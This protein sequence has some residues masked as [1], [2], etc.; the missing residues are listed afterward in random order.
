M[1]R[2]DESRIAPAETDPDNKIRKLELVLQKGETFISLLGDEGVDTGSVRRKMDEAKM[3]FNGDNMSRAFEL[4]QECIEDLIKL[5]DI[6]ERS[7][8][9]VHSL[10]RDSTTDKEV[11]RNKEKNKLKEEERR[12][13]IRSNI[14]RFRKEDFKVDVVEQLLDEDISLLEKEFNNF[15]RQV[16]KLKPL[17]E[18]LITF[19]VSGFQDDISRISG[20]MTDPANIEFIEKE[21]N[22]LEVKIVERRS[23]MRR[24]KST[25]RKWSGDGFLISK[26]EEALST[27]VPRAVDMFAEYTEKIEQLMEIERKLEK[28]RYRELD[29]Q[30]SMISLNIK[31]PDMLE[32]VKREFSF[33]ER[34]VKDLEEKKTKRNEL[35]ALLKVWKEQ[36]YKVDVVLQAMSEGDTSDGM[37]L[38]VL[39]YRKAIAALEQLKPEFQAEKRGWFPKEENFIRSNMT[40]PNRAQEVVKSFRKLKSMNS[41]EEKKRDQIERKL[42]ELSKRGI[43]TFEIESLL[44]S[45]REILMLKYSDYLP[46][47][48]TLLWLK[49]SLLK[50]GL[51]KKNTRLE[52]LA[53]KMN[54]PN[55]I[56]EYEKEAEICRSSTH[57]IQM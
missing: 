1:W 52:D 50:E 56:K 2:K 3:H 41:M 10:I 55:R 40:D 54:D 23:Q 32:D 7:K 17:K 44:H 39:D 14:D 53:R 38:I 36:G 19:D 37:E 46:K 20:S 30:I 8:K 5:K 49:A 9:E 31:N 16:A 11:P 45:D 48:K 18:K 4:S 22:A 24:I 15:I 13:E 29:D 33:V 35:N 6:H 42:K 27:D 26:L 43:E 28:I 47:V 51:A 34:K 12:K 57:E 25:I 21:M